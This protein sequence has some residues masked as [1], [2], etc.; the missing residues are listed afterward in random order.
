MSDRDVDLAKKEARRRKQSGKAKS[1]TAALAQLAAENGHD[2][3]TAYAT[4]LAAEPGPAPD[5]Q[6][7]LVSA[8]RNERTLVLSLKRVLSVTGVDNASWEQMLPAERVQHVLDC[9]L[10]SRRARGDMTR[11]NAELIESNVPSVVASGLAQAG[12]VR[13]SLG[14]DGSQPDFVVELE[15]RSSGVKEHVGVPLVE[16]LEFHGIVPADWEC[17]G[18]EEKES[19][20]E[21]MALWSKRSSG[22]FGAY[23][24]QVVSGFDGEDEPGDSPR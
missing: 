9:A 12:Q 10:S 24:S 21:E 1:Y 7:R 3:W 19:L 15:S 11:Y 2:D 5:F 14:A 6:V 8:G 20:I 17:S 18:R 22:D 16:L 4:A 23:F 13:M